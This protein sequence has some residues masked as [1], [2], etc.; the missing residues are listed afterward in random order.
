MK[1][2]LKTLLH[3]IF[4]CFEQLG[5]KLDNDLKELNDKK[6]KLSQKIENR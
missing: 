6:V 2:R 4:D 3:F 1:S 5:V